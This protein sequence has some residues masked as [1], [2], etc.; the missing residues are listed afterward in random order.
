[1]SKKT[2]IAR[3]LFTG[4]LFVVPAIL[5][6]PIESVNISS[7]GLNVG[8]TAAQ[9]QEDEGGS[10]RRTR[11]AMAIS[12]SVNKKLAAVSELLNPAEEGAK[13]DLQG[14]LREALDIN[15][16]SWNEFE[17][18]QLYNMLGGIYVQ[19]EQYDKAIDY[20]KRYVETPSVP[21]ANMLNVS[22]YLAQLYLATENYKEAI[23]LLEQYIAQSEIV[24]ADHY[25]KLGQAYYMNEQ[26]DKALP[27]IDRAVT[28]YEQSDRLPPEGL[29][30]YQMSLYYS[31]EQYPKVI[32]VLEKLVR[33]YPKISHWRTLAQVYGLAGRPQD[34]V[35]AFDAVYTMGGLSQE[36]ELRL[37]AS[38]YLEQEYPYK[39]AKILQKG[40]DEG[41]VE[42][43]SKNLELLAGAW[44]LAKEQDK[45]IPVLEQAAAKSGDGELFGRL[46]QLYLS[47]DE[48]QKSVEAARQALQRDLEKP[49]NV[50]LYLGMSLFN[51]EKFDEALK[52]FR[53]ARKDKNVASQANTWIRLVESEKAR[54]AKLEEETA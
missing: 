21:L 42:K 20:Y 3:S 26:L 12:E 1:M 32:E 10:G 54:I 37:L 41:N 50:Q 6:A 51:L 18:A 39:A 46:S 29:Y 8:L 23:R 5:L 33:H 14:A 48:Y 38:L 53:E 11:R 13:P 52:A 16:S 31:Q 24:G 36:K 28:M 44:S 40:V 27:N 7:H 17:Q 45:S 9:A 2:S 4:A 34:Q 30:Q 22:Y 43:T 15:T 35:H 25:Y 19:L 49:S 47:I